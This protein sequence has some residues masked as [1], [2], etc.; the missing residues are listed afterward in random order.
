MELRWVSSGRTAGGAQGAGSSAFSSADTMFRP[1]I[2]PAPTAYH[3]TI[4][5][6]ENMPLRPA[7]RFLPGSCF[8][9]LPPARLLA[10]RRCVVGAAAHACCSDGMRIGC[11]TLAVDGRGR[12]GPGRPEPTTRASGARSSSRLT[13]G[14]CLAASAGPPW[15][16]LA[17]CCWRWPWPAHPRLQAP[18]S[19]ALAQWVSRCGVTA[20]RGL[21]IP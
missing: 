1:G 17:A 6:L 21:P 14:R 12:S 7:E 19:S 18:P 9:R 3:P 8:T 20:A 2:A 11:S 16:P 15:G 4:V 13:G 10:S 5:L